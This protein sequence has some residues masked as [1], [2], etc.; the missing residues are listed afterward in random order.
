MAKTDGI[1]TTPQIQF[2]TISDSPRVHRVNVATFSVAKSHKKQILFS[3]IRYPMGSELN[4]GFNP[5]LSW[6]HYR[7]LTRV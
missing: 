5:Q 7:T 4:T 1:Y 6:S 2:K 3:I